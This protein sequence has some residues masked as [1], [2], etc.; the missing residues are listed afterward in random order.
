M[1]A[2]VIKAMN[3]KEKKETLRKWW[4]VNGYKVLRVVLFPI[5]IG[6]I[7]A[8]KIQNKLNAR[9]FW[10]EERA[11]EIL[12]YYVPRSAEWDDEEK[13]FYLF[14]NG[15]GWSIGLAKRHLKRKDRRFWEL[16]NGFCGGRIR[17][18]LIEDFELE[19]FTKIIG[20]CSDTFTEITFK[21]N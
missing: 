19:G 16:H 17:T 20:N 21:L 2:E 11:D 1:N 12:N 9:N 5:W 3:K 13:E 6:S 14:D 18:F 4:K 15:W 7:I 10:S 8:E